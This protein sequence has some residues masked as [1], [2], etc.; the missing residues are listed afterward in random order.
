MSKSFSYVLEADG[1]QLAFGERRILSDVYLRVETGQVVGLLGRN[2]CGKSTCCKLS[3]VA[4][5]SPTPPCG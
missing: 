1:M 3:L 2:G 5:T 4:A